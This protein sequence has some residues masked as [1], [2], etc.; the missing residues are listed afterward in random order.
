ML[1]TPS[2]TNDAG[3][4]ILIAKYRTVML[5]KAPRMCVFIILVMCL[6]CQS[7]SEMH[8]LYKR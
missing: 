4:R 2:Y 3:F 5:V 8:I 6:L 7:P 1:L